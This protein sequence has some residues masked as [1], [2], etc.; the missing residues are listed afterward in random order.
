MRVLFLEADT[1]RSWAV[2]SI[3]PGFLGAALR[4]AGH[5]AEL[6]RAGLDAS[7]ADVAALV[8]ARA[9]DLIGVS[10]TTRQWL[11][12]RELVAAIR[13]VCDVPVIAGGLHPTFSPQEVLASPG[14]DYVCLGEGEDAL[15]DLVA[16]LES[17]GRTDRLA[18][19]WKRGGLRP[20]LRP[21]I[22]PIDRLPFMARDL[23][24]EANGV[25]HMTT[26]R[27]CPF[28]CTYCAAR[29]YNQLYEGTGEYG[30]RRSHANVLAEL[31]ALRE[32]GKL[33]YVIFLDDTFTIHHPWV[34][35]F[36]QV[37][38][39][40]LRAPFS[41][42]A[43]V[44]TVNE[45]LLHTL[46]AAG[47]DQITYG[48]ESGSERIR[49]EVMQRPVTNDRFRDVFRW[50]REAGIRLTANFMLGLPGETRDD[51]EQTIVLAEELGVLDFG[52]FVF[53]P[54]PGTALFRVC[55]ERGYLPADYL[56]RPANHRASILSLPDL[57]NDDIAEYYD[58]FTDLRRRLYA[59]RL[60]IAP[61]DLVHQATD[62]VDHLA[63][64][65]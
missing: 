63:G 35:E 61:P 20:G 45:K 6:L 12:G 4:A 1:E 41:L 29:M 15:L 36:C 39:E 60:G 34:R 18:N 14:F 9:P 24:D 21:P 38:G 10:L 19:I 52:Y 3:G 27:G 7:P 59:E 11:R 42:H 33:A 47:C 40:R 13:E 53:Y 25:V 31:T 32:A 30:R 54:Y 44:E 22:D 65:G 37:Y 64:T 23:L 28:P 51:L 62:H 56:E 55:E 17:G 26:Q 16:A 50:T 5:E 58:R 43:R 49:R 46:K 48:V 57:G 8:A 2:A